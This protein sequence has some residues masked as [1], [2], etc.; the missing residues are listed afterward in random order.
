MANTEKLGSYHIAAN[1]YR[2]YEPAKSNCFTLIVHDLNNLL[3]VDYAYRD[4]GED[5]P[6]DDYIKDASEIIK[7]SVKSFTP[8]HFNLGVITIRRGNSITK[9][10]DVPEWSEQTV[11][12]EDYVGLNDKA[13]IMAWQALAYD[14]MSDTQGRAINYKKNCTLVEYTPDFKQVRYWELIGCWISQVSESPF[15]VDGS[16][17]RKINATLQYDR[18]IMHMPDGTTYTQVES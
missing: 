10:A 5:I 17:D 1:N 7:L 11:E 2:D 14:V 13:V 4:R 8:P 15:E 12:L 18:A 16:G 9:Y 6:E 3:P